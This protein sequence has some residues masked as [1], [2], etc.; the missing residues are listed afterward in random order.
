M[1]FD[2]L[3]GMGVVEELGSVDEMEDGVSYMVRMGL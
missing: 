1:R 2:E 3:V